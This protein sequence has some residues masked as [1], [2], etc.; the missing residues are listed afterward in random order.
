MAHFAVI[1]APVNQKNIIMRKIVIIDADC[2]IFKKVVENGKL[3]ERMIGKDEFEE[4]FDKVYDGEKKVVY[5]TRKDQ[6]VM[7]RE[8]RFNGL[9]VSN[10]YNI[11]DDLRKDD[12]VYV[13][14]M[15]GDYFN[16]D[17]KDMI[18]VGKNEKDL[19]DAKAKGLS[20]IKL[21]HTKA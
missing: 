7:R 16:K 1:F 17:M 3:I 9:R 19:N 18:F 12:F 10:I 20:V 15:I 5:I 14:G 6:D 8:I 4:M 13:M 11:H 2:V 21:Q